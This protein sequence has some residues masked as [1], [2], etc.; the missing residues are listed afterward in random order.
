ML[1]ENMGKPFAVKHKKAGYLICV[2]VPFG[3]LIIL[4]QLERIRKG[5]VV[6]LALYGLNILFTIFA[7]VLEN[8]EELVIIVLSLV[9]VV[10]GL[11]AH[12]WIWWH[13]YSKW[14][15]EWELKNKE[16]S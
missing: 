16:S 11:V 12:F 8:S 1:S 9:I 14:V 2:F 3:W 4:G 13:F 15:E 7:G 5:I 10:I 6:G